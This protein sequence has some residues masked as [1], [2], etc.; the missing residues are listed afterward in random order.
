[1]L[2]SNPPIIPQ[3][4]ATE[5]TAAIIPEAKQ[6]FGR[7]SWQQGFPTETAIPLNAGGIPPH[8]ADFNGAYKMISQHTFFGQSGCVY[9]WDATLNYLSN[10]HVVGSDGNEYA[11]KQASGPDTRSST[12]GGAIVGPKDP[13]LDAE[14]EGEYWVNISAKLGYGQGGGGGTTGGGGSYPG[15]IQIF[16]G[17][18]GGTDNRF[19]IP[20]GATDPLEDWVMCDGGSDGQGGLVP[21]LRGRFVIGSSSSYPIG[22]TGGSTTASGSISGTVGS[23]TLSVSQMPSH[24]H[25]MRWGPNPQGTHTGYWGASGESSGASTFSTGGSS[26][27]THSLSSASV[28]LNIMPPYYALA[29]IIKIA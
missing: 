14:G 4:F 15:F 6:E 1:M 28:S 27:H 7:A 22:R 13:V 23:T 25:V 20:R 9:P 24:S 2:V 17:V 29:Y 11:A 21:D 10:S 19:P 8:Q 26:S 3:P 12:G 18:F 16:S 5:G